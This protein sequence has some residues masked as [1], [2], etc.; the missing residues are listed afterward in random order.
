MGRKFGAIAA[1]FLLVATTA[2]FIN[3]APASGQTA[4]APGDTA[5]ITGAAK[6]V[7][8]GTANH[9]ALLTVFNAAGSPILECHGVLISPTWVL[10]SSSCADA[11]GAA[12]TLVT[13]GATN[14]AKPIKHDFENRV[15]VDS[16]KH[17][18]ADDATWGSYAYEMALYKLNSAS[19]R[20][21]ALL[22]ATALT[23]ADGSGTLQGYGPSTSRGSDGGTLRSGKVDFSTR[24]RTIDIFGKVGLSTNNAPFADFILSEGAS[25][26]HVKSCDDPGAP[27]ITNV[28][29]KPTVLALASRQF[30]YQGFGICNDAIDEYFHFY[31]NVTSPTNSKWITS[32]VGKTGPARDAKCAG[33]PAT[34]FGTNKADKMVGTSGADVMVGLNGNDILNGAN[35]KDRICGGKG[36]DALIGGK[37]KDICDGGKQKDRKPQ[38]CEKKKKI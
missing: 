5:Q 34:I 11:P 13:L 25:S 33:K 3:S 20:R 27:V 36:V 29:G 17:P 6:A 16:V 18:Q 37:G 24:A 12:R 8:P 2:L 4:D 31:F 9:I 22:G 28:K 19:T 26:T 35:G 21:P 32:V 1:A 38:Q 23:T 7:K 15:A 10:S 30:V 14:V